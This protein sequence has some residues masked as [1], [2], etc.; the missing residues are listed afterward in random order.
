MT[1][2]RLAVVTIVRARHA[3][4]ERQLW[5]LRAQSRPA[6]LHVVVAMA[7]EGVR[8]VVAASCGSTETHVPSIDLYRGRLPLAAARNL[9]VA[10]AVAAGARQLVLLDVDC[11]P[12]P[13]LVERYAQVLEMCDA[14]PPGSSESETDGSAGRATGGPC[15]L[16]GEVAYLPPAP[17]GRD[18]RQLDLNALASPH[19]AR[20]SLAAGEVRVAHDLR[21]FWS[22]SFALS[23]RSWSAIGGFDEGYVGY[24]GEDTD[25]AQRLGRAGGRL[26][27]VGGAVA[28]H[29]HHATSSPPL[30][31][32]R[33]IVTNANRF[34][35][36]WGWW[37]MQGWLD[38]FATRGIARRRADG[39]WELVPN[40]GSHC[41]PP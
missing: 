31:H 2:A 5:A 1:A 18:Y 20:P 12:S 36:L 7:D 16:S 24:G 21:L 8:S 25:F 29:Q 3:H 41:L 40:A 34:A 23:V 4:L 19:P 30:E 22:L 17:D 10:T 15:V 35:R 37:P 38:A 33:D 9:G 26:L 11:I 39:T 32:A 6:D 27:W 13:T 28:F 14:D